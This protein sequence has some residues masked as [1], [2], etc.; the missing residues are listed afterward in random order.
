[1][2]FRNFKTLKKHLK[3]H[4]FEYDNFGRENGITM[5]GN[6]YF[7]RRTRNWDDIVWLRIS[8]DDINKGLTK[9]EVTGKI[10]N[11]VYNWRNHDTD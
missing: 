2:G 9:K 10:M 3:Q 1:M 11:A 8:Q 4:G 7:F 6:H 5:S